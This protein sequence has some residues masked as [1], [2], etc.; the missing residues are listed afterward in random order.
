[1]QRQEP[2][3]LGSSR[4]STTVHPPSALVR[5]GPLHAIDRRTPS[6]MSDRP[7]SRVS[8]MCHPHPRL[9]ILITL[10]GGMLLALA[11]QTGGQT[12]V[13]LAVAGRASA[14]PALAARGAFVVAAW[15]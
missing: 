2:E 7:D 10:L 9:R 15:G 14:N 5:A 8:F 1:M 4:D 11:Q 6:R 13:Q 3:Q 12:L